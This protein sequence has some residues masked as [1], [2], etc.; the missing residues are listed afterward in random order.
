MPEESWLCCS[1]CSAKQCGLLVSSLVFLFKPRFHLG[2]FIFHYLKEEK[3]KL[4]FLFLK[5]IYLK[6]K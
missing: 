1:F 3:K 2:V 6:L 4:I 5:C